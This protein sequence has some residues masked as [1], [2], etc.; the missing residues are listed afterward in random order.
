M[1]GDTDFGINKRRL[2]MTELHN[3]PEEMQQDIK[4]RM[5]P[6][7]APIFLEDGSP[8]ISKLN[9]PEGHGMGYS[10]KTGQ[11]YISLEVFLKIA[12]QRYWTDEERDQAWSIQAD[13]R[14][15]VLFEEANKIKY[16]E[17]SGDQFFDGEDYF[18]DLETYFEGITEALG[19]DYESYP[20]YV[21]ATEERPFLKP[22]DVHGIFE[23]D[24]EEAGEWAYEAF[25][26]AIGKDELN[27]ALN[28]FVEKNKK[29]MTLYFPDYSTAL[30]L[31]DELAK[32]IKEIAE[33][34]LE[35]T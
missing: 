18:P 20:K 9:N 4:A 35:E 8:V 7:F 12:Y 10:R 28:D 6:D 27:Q 1:F 5:I 16:A 14:E 24:L 2:I 33:E 3:L 31:D 30:L 32:R 17:W 29:R 26:G 34:E 19:Y 25:T 11:I 22:K 15:K 23:N 21:W 13:K